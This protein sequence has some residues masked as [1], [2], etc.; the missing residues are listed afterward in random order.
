MIYMKKFEK[1]DILYEEGCFAGLEIQINRIKDNGNGDLEY[2]TMAIAELLCGNDATS[3]VEVLV[4]YS[5]MEKINQVINSF[6]TYQM[7]FEKAV[8]LPIINISG[9][10]FVGFFDNNNN[11]IT[12]VTIDV[13][14]ELVAVY[15]K[16]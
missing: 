11:I 15:I 13:E 16:K 12:K 14:T 1:L 8:S 6:G 2:V 5:T 9:Y 4:D 3:N 7:I 10:N